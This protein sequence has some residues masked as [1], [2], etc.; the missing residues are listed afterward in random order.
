MLTASR[1]STIVTSEW[2]GWMKRV[3]SWKRQTSNRNRFVSRHNQTFKAIE[4]LV[5]SCV[6]SSGYERRVGRSAKRPRHHRRGSATSARTSTRARSSTGSMLLRQRTCRE[7]VH[8]DACANPRTRVPR[9]WWWRQS[10]DGTGWQ[11]DVTVK[12]SYDDNDD[13]WALFWFVVAARTWRPEAATRTAHAGS[14]VRERHVVSVVA[15]TVWR[16]ASFPFTHC[17]QFACTLLSLN[18]MLLY[19]L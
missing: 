6:D 7:A 4:Y 12:S 5:C 19:V 16:H 18:D 14:D 3:N 11:G 2:R 15:Y 10:A 9:G 1:S 8:H 13:E 17:T